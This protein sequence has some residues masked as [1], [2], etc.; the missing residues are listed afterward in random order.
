MRRVLF[1]SE[2]VTLAQVVR[3][4]TLARALDPTRFDVH[5]AA[6]HFDE[7]IFAETTFTRHSNPL[8]GA[9]HRRGACGIGPPDLRRADA[10]PLCRRG[11]D[12]A[13]RAR[14]S[15]GRGGFAALVIGIG[16]PGTNSLRLPHQRVLEPACRPRGLPAPRPSDREPSGGPPRGPLFPQ[17]PAVGLPVLRATGERA[18]RPGTGSRRLAVFPKCSPT[19]I[20]RCSPMS[21]R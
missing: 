18:A 7:M 10:A 16:G 13:A 15:P 17:G 4:A 9:R 14:P 20:A 5:F 1:V 19:V 6:S 21:P 11:A 2:A 12:A 3:L 8:A